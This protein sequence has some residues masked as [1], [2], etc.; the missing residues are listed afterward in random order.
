M[1]TTVLD[2]K[3]SE[4]AANILHELLSSTESDNNTQT[5]CCTSDDSELF[6]GKKLKMTYGL[7]KAP[8]CYLI[9]ILAVNCQLMT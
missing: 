9:K 8:N 1:K 2:C 4:L 6:Q 7:P 5:D 3:Q